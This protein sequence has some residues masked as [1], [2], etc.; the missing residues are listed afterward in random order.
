MTAGILYNKST[1]VTAIV[2]QVN[3][4][5]FL[6]IFDIIVEF[7][8]RF[9]LEAEWDFTA[10][11]IRHS[12]TTNTVHGIKFTMIV[13]VVCRIAEYLENSTSSQS[14]SPN[15]HISSVILLSNR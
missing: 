8:L 15:A 14:G 4:F 9:F 10:F 5:S 6:S 3:R 11:T 12:T 1:A 13:C 7:K 2:V